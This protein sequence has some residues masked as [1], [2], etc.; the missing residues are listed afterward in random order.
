MLAWD[1]DFDRDL[2]KMASVRLD[3][4]VTDSLEHLLTQ[5]QQLAAL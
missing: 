2:E 5:R 4:A 1:V 3:A